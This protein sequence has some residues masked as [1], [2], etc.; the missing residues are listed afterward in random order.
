MKP[1]LI[2]D[3]MVLKKALKIWIWV[4]FIIL[5]VILTMVSYSFLSIF[6]VS[7]V[8]G[9]AIAYDEQ[10]K[11]K[12]YSYMLPYS[13]FEFVVS[14]YLV[15]Y[16]SIGVVVGVTTIVILMKNLVGN[17]SMSIY[18][19]FDM[20]ILEVSLV[21]IF[22]SILIWTQLKYGYQKSRFINTIFIILVTIFTSLISSAGT[23]ID[24]AKIIVGYDFLPSIM[25][26]LAIICNLISIKCSIGIEKE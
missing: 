4:L 8:A 11:W 16:I 2:K 19:G 23:V 5:P 26:V 24:V 20:L 6:I 1:L 22:T 21:L 12:E 7:T 17:Q 10:C 14:K 25:F 9:T 3:F 15:S 18:A 13:K